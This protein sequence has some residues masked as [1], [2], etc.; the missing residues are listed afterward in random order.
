MRSALPS[1]VKRE[2]VL[3]QPLRL[4]LQPNRERLHFKFRFVSAAF[5]FNCFPFTLH[6]I[7][8]YLPRVRYKRRVSRIVIP[9][10]IYENSVVARFRKKQHA[11]VLSRS[12]F[13][14][15]RSFSTLLYS[16]SESVITSETSYICGFI[17]VCLHCKVAFIFSLFSAEIILSF[18]C[19][20]R[21]YLKLHVIKS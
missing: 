19:R 12:P 14:I 4:F 1:A 20:K 16:A 17:S 13:Q 9:L 8:Y 6:K 11:G 21:H 15:S 2:G 10:R 18:S 7:F 5:Y 3:L